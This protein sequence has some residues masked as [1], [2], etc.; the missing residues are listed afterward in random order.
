MQLVVQTEYGITRTWYWPLTAPFQPF[1]RERQVIGPQTTVDDLE[2]RRSGDKEAQVKKINPNATNMTLQGDDD[3]AS[4]RE[5]I[6][7]SDATNS[8]PVISMASK[9]FGNKFAVRD[10]SIAVGSGEILVLLGLNVD[11][12][13]TLVNCVLGL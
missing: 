5:R 3:V 13:M 7:S 2:A 12:K 9:R 11:G 8:P 10:V 1:R 6:T 4:E